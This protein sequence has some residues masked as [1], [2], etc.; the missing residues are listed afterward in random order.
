MSR[1][2]R[3]P[4]IRHCP[5]VLLIVGTVLAAPPA[6]ARQIDIQGPAGSGAFGTS[7]T[8]LPNGNFVVTDPNASIGSVS[9]V[10][11]VYLYSPIPALISTLTGSSINDNVG[12]GGVVVIGD[13]NFVVR[14]PAWNNIGAAAAGAVTWVN[15]TTGLSGVV[16][17]SNSLIGTTAGDQIGQYDVMALSNGN[18]VV[19]SPNWNNGVIGANVGAATWGNGS[20]GITGPVSPSN[21]LFGTTVAD[22]VGFPFALRNGNYVVASRDW[23]NGVA[24]SNVGAA[25]WGNG[26]TGITGPVTTSNSLVGTAAGD[27]IGQYGITALSNGNYVVD[28]GSWNNGQANG[29]FGAA[30][31]G[32]GSSGITG[33]VSPSN[34]LVGT[35]VG[36]QVGLEVTSLSN[37][38]YVVASIYWHYYFGAA[39]WGNGSSGI[40]G[41]VT[42]SNSLVGTT[43]DDYVGDGVIA[44]SN[45]NYVVVSWDWNNG[46]S[47]NHYGAATWGNGSTGIAGP[48]TVSNSLFGTTANDYVGNG[49]NVALRNGDYVIASHTWNNYFG[50][51]TWGNGSTGITGP[52]TT[53]N[54]LVGTTTGDDVGDSVTALTNGNYVVFSP[55]WNNGIANSNVGA[56]TWGNGNSGITGPVTVSNSL[57]GTTAGDNVGLGPPTGLSNGALDDGNYVVISSNWNDNVASSHVGAATWGNGMSGIAGPVAAGN[58]LVGTAAGDQVSRYGPFP[59]SD[60]N[61]VLATDTWSGNRGAITLGNGTF[62]LKGTIQAWNSVLGTAANGGALMSHAYDPGH[63]VLIVGRPADNIV[64]LFT[65]D[66]IFADNFE[67]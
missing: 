36:D 38:N 8:E 16:S 3:R 59:M 61:Y 25:T 23:N 24:N 22:H 2:K 27:Q 12:S 57:Y 63:Q 53:S 39:T 11:A 10:G 6:G 62:R 34:S 52:V 9:K 40:T 15:G 67:Q 37:G 46:A 42:A 18:F 7:V 21:S 33:P 35:T 14:S 13:G 66:Q 58:S 19:A 47:G 5:T 26:S 64:S 43:A 65:M 60:G 30:T 45:G 1:K 50:A 56:A 49:G 29:M 55:D 17:A 28:S 44:L 54:S 31:W 51:A 20:S 48:V 4:L 41:P 32:N